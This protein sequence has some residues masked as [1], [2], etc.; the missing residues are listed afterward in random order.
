VSSHVPLRNWEHLPDI[1]GGVESISDAL[2]IREKSFFL[3]TEK[4]GDVPSGNNR[5]LGLYHRDTRHLSTY[6]FS[7]NGS[8]PVVLLSTADSGYSMEQVMG[9]HRAITD[10]R[11]VVGRCTVEVVRERVFCDGIE[12]KVGSR[13]TTCRFSACPPEYAFGADF[14]DVFEVRGHARHQAGHHHPA[15][16]SECSIRY[17]YSGIDGALRS[18]RIILTHPGEDNREPRDLRP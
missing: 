3:L 10:T 15:E 8:Q 12:E 18:T 5:G 6:D 17:C 13:T 9:N 14:A 2:I 11:Q 16:V 4:T 7:L 1:F